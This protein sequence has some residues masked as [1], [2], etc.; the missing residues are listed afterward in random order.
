MPVRKIS[1]QQIPDVHQNR[2]ISLA[3]IA[4]CLKGQMVAGHRAATMT[5][6]G[7]NFRSLAAEFSGDQAMI[8]VASRRNIARITA[9]AQDLQGQ[10]WRQGNFLV[11]FKQHHL[12]LMLKGAHPPADI[13]ASSHQL[14]GKQAGA[15]LANLGLQG[16]RFTGLN[17]PNIHTSD[18]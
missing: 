9:T 11:I 17:K 13:M 16:Q 14:I 18:S 3:S 7:S 2:N 1:G 15:H 10:S 5:S 6:G 12:A 4:H 8:K